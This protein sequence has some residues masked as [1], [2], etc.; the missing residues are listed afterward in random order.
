MD[1]GQHG[2]RPNRSTLTQLSYQYDTILEM[3]LDGQN[4][5]ILYLDFEK[6]FDKVDLGLLLIKI[7]KL[8]IKGKLGAWLGAFTLGR[9]QAVR[10]GTKLSSWDEVILGVTTRICT[11]TSVIFNLYI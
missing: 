5:D 10:V 8:G 1:E 2:C 6:A 11:R 3:L 7:E 9:I 4:V